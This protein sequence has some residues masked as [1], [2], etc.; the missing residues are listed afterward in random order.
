VD[1]DAREA[2]VGDHDVAAARED[3]QRVAGG[4]G[5]PDGAEKLVLGR[6]RHE[7]PGRAAEAQRRQVGQTRGH[8]DEGR[9]RRTAPRDGGDHLVVRKELVLVPVDDAAS[10]E[11]VRRDLDAHAVSREHADAET[12]H[13]AGEVGEDGVAVLELH[14]EHRVGQRFDDFTVESDL[15]FNCYWRSPPLMSAR[16]IV[17][18]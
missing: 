13:L 1:D 17:P 6:G 12:A 11:V 14:A 2:L 9:G 4:V 3:Q 8:L 7:A 5:L 10:I 18:A 15:L 16:R